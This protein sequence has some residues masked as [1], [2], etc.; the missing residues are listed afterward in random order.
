M[1]SLKLIYFTLLVIFTAALLSCTA[2]A[3]S[4]K[5]DP[6]RNVRLPAVASDFRG[7]YP[8]TPSKLED[9][10]RGFLQ[11]SEM[12]KLDGVPVA[13]IVPHAGYI[14]SG[15]V[16][17]AAFKQLVGAHINTVFIIGCSHQHRFTKASLPKYDCYRTPLGDV[18]MDLQAVDE[19]LKDGQFFASDVQYLDWQTGKNTSVHATEHSLEVEIP[20]MQTVLSTFSIVPV[21]LGTNDLDICRKIG[22]RLAEVASSRKG[23]LIVCSTDLTHYPKYDDASRIDRETLNYIQTMD[24]EK[25]HQY[26][27]SFKMTE[28]P[29]LAT[30]MCGEGAVYSTLAAAKALG[31]NKA[32]LIRYANSGDAATPYADKRRVVG[33]GAMLIT[34][35][36]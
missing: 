15:P 30:L 10:I 7:F 36:R 26:V 35:P 22:A 6:C 24:L 11:E 3:E 14:F 9:M 23:S 12:V 1:K 31:A 17:A 32:S 18:P 21:L 28:I 34:K 5:K 2:W 20:F 8:S 4:E 16:A 13:L 25:L 27:S 19:L 29:G 33:Y